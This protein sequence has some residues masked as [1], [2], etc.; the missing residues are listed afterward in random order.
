MCTSVCFKVSSRSHLT[1][2]FETAL[3]LV[4]F[5]FSASF[6][7]LCWSFSYAGKLKQHIARWGVFPW[8]AT[9]GTSQ[10]LWTQTED[11]DEADLSACTHRPIT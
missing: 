9:H 10:L 11:A 4:A 2:G 7:F 1:E 5:V 8:S 3:S 6:V